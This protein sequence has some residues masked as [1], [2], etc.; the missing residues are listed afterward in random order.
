MKIAI[1]TG[2]AQG[3]GRRT[4]EVLAS[5]GFGLLLMDMQPCTATLAA[6]RAAGVEADEVLGDLSDEA[7]VERGVEVVRR[8][9]GRVDALVNNAGISFYLLRQRRWRPRSF[10]ECWR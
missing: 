2:A 5:A 10:D 4:A 9:W 1:V 3:I 8:R 7:V 6:V